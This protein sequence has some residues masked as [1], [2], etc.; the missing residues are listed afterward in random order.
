MGRR[1]AASQMRMWTFR[2]L[3]GLLAL[4]GLTPAAASGQARQD[5]VLLQG[6]VVEEHTG[7]PIAFASL[8]IM[9][10]DL[11]LL[12]RAES[13][14]AGRFS[15][16]VRK[17]PGVYLE[18]Q[19]IGYEETL[20]PFLWFDGHDHFELEV[21][22]DREVVLHAPLEVVGRRRAESPVLEAFRHR[23]RMGMGYYVT[24]DQIE[25]RN[26]SRV[27]DLLAEAP[28]V[29]LT[30]SG[31]G[32]R[33]VVEMRG[34]ASS[35]GCPVQVYIDGMHLNDNEGPP[36]VQV[37]AIDDFVSPESVFGIEIYRGLSTVPAEFLNTYARCGVVAL[38]TLRGG[39]ESE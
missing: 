36:D 21:R 30:S 25:A 29:R 19:R 32:F 20:A 9:D 27:T 39:S 28:G 11:R 14:R 33:R 2:A 22:L 17:Q 24:R 6:R 23:T 10:R 16:A 7:E 18:V 13:D 37:V 15:Y 31:L 8:R 5:S 26:P 35:G 12:G 4:A 1:K 34:G 3:W 38:W